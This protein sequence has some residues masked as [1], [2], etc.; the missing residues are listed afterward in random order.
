MIDHITFGVIDFE[1][2]VEFYDEALRPLGISRLFTVPLE[3]AD[4]VFVTGYGDTRP[5]FWIAQEDA[6]RGKL[7]IALSAKDRASVDAF[8]AAAMSVGGKDNG[9]P[10]LRPHYHHDYYGAFILDPDGHTIE[11]VCHHPEPSG[12]PARSK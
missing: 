8:H 5:W 3:Q 1:R 7:H 11:A 12:M 9:A 10:G 6:T 4:G 2:S